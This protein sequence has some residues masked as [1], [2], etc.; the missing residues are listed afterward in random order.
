MQCTLFR[1][2]ISFSFL[3][4]SNTTQYIIGKLVSLIYSFDHFLDTAGQLVEKYGGGRSVEKQCPQCN[5]KLTLK[6]AGVLIGENECI[7]VY[8]DDDKFVCPYCNY[9]EE[10]ILKPK[11]TQS[12]PCPFQNA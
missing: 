7:A 3:N 12:L 11:I 5:E 9:V 10:D 6:T 4:K 1:C 2:S 8:S